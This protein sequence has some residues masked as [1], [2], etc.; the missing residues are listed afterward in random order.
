MSPR[1]TKTPKVVVK[2]V[3]LSDAEWMALQR[4]RR[5]KEGVSAFLRRMLVG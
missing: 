4:K 5:P 2:S 1:K 3:R